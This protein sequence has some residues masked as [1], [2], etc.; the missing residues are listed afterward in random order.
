MSLF[1]KSRKPEAAIRSATDL[2]KSSTDLELRNGDDALELAR[3]EMREGKFGSAL[4]LLNAAIS[5]DAQNVKLW[6][7]RGS[8]FYEWGRFYEAYQTYRTASSMFPENINLIARLAWSAHAVGKNSDAET[9]MRRVLEAR[10]NEPDACFGLGTVLRAQKQLEPALESFLQAIELDSQFA[11]AH[12]NAGVTL[13]DLNRF[14]QAE[15]H[16]RQAIELAPDD[17]GNWVNLGVNLYRQEKDGAEESY[18]RAQQLEVQTGKSV[19]AFVGY[20]TYLRNTG[21]RSEAI[22]QYRKHL[23]RHPNTAALTQYGMCL[24]QEADFLR[25][26]SL[27]EFRWLQD[28]L[29]SLRANLDLPQWQG[30]EVRGKTILV[31]AE[32]G[33]GD[34]IQFAR[35]LREIK[36]LGGRVLFQGRDGMEELTRRFEGID[37]IINTGEKLPEFDYFANLMSLPRFFGNDPKLVSSPGPYVRNDSARTEAFRQLMDCSDL[38]IG[39]VWGGNPTHLQ[40]KVRSVPLRELSRILAIP[41]VRLFSLQKGEAAR[42]LTELDHS[43]RIVDWAPML[44]TFAD[45]AD[46]IAALDLIISVDTSVAHLAGALE[47]PVWILL[48]NPAEW[49]WMDERSDSDWYRTARLFRQPTSGDWTSVV[50]EVARAIPLY[51]DDHGKDT[52]PPAETHAE[53]ICQSWI[54]QFVPP[55]VAADLTSIGEVREGIFQF[56]AD[57]TNSEG[58]SLSSYGEWHHDQLA[59]L[60][61]MVKLGQVVAEVGSSVGVHTVALSRLVGPDGHVIAF[62]NNPLARRI[63]SQNLPANRARNVTIMQ[64]NCGR[65]GGEAPSRSSDTI[66]NLELDRLD[67]LKT[68]DSGDVDFVLKGAERTIWRSRPKLFVNVDSDIGALASRIAGF[69]YACWLHRSAVFRPR[70]FNRLAQPVATHRDQMA[71][72]AIP[73]EVLVDVDMSPCERIAA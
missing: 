5:V 28:P 26:W 33:I 65:D 68:N 43:E 57:P 29:I 31:R 49:R 69:G 73:E 58:L 10:P 4:R 38:N 50:E 44:C 66:D 34:V 63:L 21:R 40:D 42:Q 19:D 52:S 55:C 62:E 9:L 8:V 45:T 11:H 17:P 60:A 48:Q 47:K 54:P 35:Y 46:A 71:I 24:L 59:L 51:R 3:I 70:N 36:S 39:I 23:P 72:V 7:A 64:T 25:G 67:W 61:R 22:A 18:F 56:F 32:Q 15:T 1:R 27:Y 41:G 53:T 16:L 13:M 37:A 30:Q 12:I 6:L 14:E 20:A 2:L